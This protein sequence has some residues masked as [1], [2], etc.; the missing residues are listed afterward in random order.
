[1]RV[2]FSLDK[3][4]RGRVPWSQRI[5]DGVFDAVVASCSSNGGSE[6]SIS[7]RSRDFK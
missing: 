7:R 3:R 1:M 6:V 5:E 2:S 4:S